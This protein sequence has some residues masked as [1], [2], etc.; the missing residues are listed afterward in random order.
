MPCHNE[1]P[2][3]IQPVNPDAPPQTMP[4]PLKWALPIIIG[5][6][7]A[8]LLFEHRMHLGAILPWLL[9]AGCALMHLFMHRGHGA[10]DHS[11]HTHERHR[12]RDD[13]K[14]DR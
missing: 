13:R 11:G 14:A 10:H 5:L 2:R 7:A 6:I 12:T 1:A 3:K 8:L 9:L 4:N